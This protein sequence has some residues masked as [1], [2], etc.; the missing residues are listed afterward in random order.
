[1]DKKEKI[2]NAAIMVFSRK[3]YEATM[4]E[5]ASEAGVSKGLLFFYYESKENLIIESALKSLPIYIINSVNNGSYFDAN[6][7]LYDLGI[8]FLYY[9]KNQDL[10]NLFL[11]TI[12]NKNRYDIL[13]DRLKYLCFTSFD[14][15][16]DKVEKMIN[17]RLSIAK[18]RSFFG[19]LLCY[20]IWWDENVQSI[21]EYTKDLVKEFLSF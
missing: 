7:V 4:D 14:S 17:R 13:K 16:F 12:S 19:S 1:M 6:N 5:I 3:G 15:V 8:K 11:Y 2:L 10:R 9:Y 18:K 21:E 20:L